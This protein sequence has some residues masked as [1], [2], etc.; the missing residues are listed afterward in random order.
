MCQ[1]DAGWAI[2]LVASEVA[3]GSALD[4]QLN[5]QCAGATKRIS[6]KNP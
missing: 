5:Q 6:L 3:G 4:Q 2:L 1:G